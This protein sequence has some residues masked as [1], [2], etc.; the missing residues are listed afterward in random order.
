MMDLTISRR[1]A[2][3]VEVSLSTL[4][5]PEALLPATLRDLNM[6]LIRSNLPLPSPVMFEGR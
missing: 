6:L 2:V 4:L 3:E 5:L 1:N